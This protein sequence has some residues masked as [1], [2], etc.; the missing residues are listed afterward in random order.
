VWPVAEGVDPADVY[1]AQQWQREEWLGRRTAGEWME[2]D[3]L[4]LL[5]VRRLYHEDGKTVDLRTGLASPKR[6]RL[7]GLIL[8]TLPLPPELT[9]RL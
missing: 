5:P 7:K 8:A 9:E 3:P 4:R 2:E 1:G 6:P